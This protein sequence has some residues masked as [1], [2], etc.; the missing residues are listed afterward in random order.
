[1]NKIIFYDNPLNSSEES[2]KN[3]HYRLNKIDFF[4][5]VILHNNLRNEQI[6]KDNKK[7]FI[8]NLERI[9][10]KLQDVLSK[11][12]K[13][14]KTIKLTTL[15]TFNPKNT[16]NKNQ[17]IIDLLDEYKLFYKKNKLK[18]WFSYKFKLGDTIFKYGGIPNLSK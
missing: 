1:M 11:N 7:M 15:N 17:K 13:K 16:F 6:L 8:A 12:Q 5:L 2:K 9:I 4:E 18:R 14:S 10:Q 3:K